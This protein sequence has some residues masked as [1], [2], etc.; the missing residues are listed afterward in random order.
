MNV[1]DQFRLD[2][3]TALITGGSRG[4]G[5]AMATAFAQAGARIVIVSRDAQ[6]AETAAAELSGEFSRPMHA[7]A[8]DVSRPDQVESLYNSISQSIGNI[9]ILVNCAGLNIRGPIQ[10]LS[11]NDWDSV[12]DT[13]LK[14]PFLLNRQFGPAMAARGWGRIIHMGSILSLAG[15]AGRTPYASSKAGLLG[16]TRVLAMEWAAKG[17]TVNALCPGV[18]ATDMNLE[19]TRDPIKYQEFIQKIPMSRWGELD[20]IVAPALFLASPASSYMTGQT[21]VIDG[22][23]TAQ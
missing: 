15:I 11:L 23:W 22:G 4:L 5:R 20:E 1:L 14:A 19:L 6:S 2:N 10:D 21:L 17:V 16:L 18:F 3:R 9:D 8:C 13:N 12:V 7:F